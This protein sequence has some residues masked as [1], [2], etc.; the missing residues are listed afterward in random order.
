[1]RKG[2]VALLDAL[3]V[4]GIWARS[5]P[6]DVIT[7]WKHA[8]G[9]FE[10]SIQKAREASPE[11]KFSLLSFSDTVIILLETEK[12]PVA[13]IPL[14]AG[15]LLVPFNAALVEGIFLRGAVSV[16]EF[17][18]SE[19]MI[20]GPAVD[21]AAEWYTVPDWMGVSLCPS[22]SYGVERLAEQGA[23]ISRWFVKY[24]VPMKSGVDGG[25][26]WALAWPRF[27]LDIPLGDEKPLSARGVLLYTFARNGVSVSVHT[28][29]RNTLRFF[30]FVRSPVEEAHRSRSSRR[31]GRGG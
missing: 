6:R 27:A 17:V 15:V 21:E 14:M 28:K 9:M 1:M 30:D 18:R 26:G 24:D 8:I 12:D 5:R 23:D 13:C 2:V 19:S 20:I 16:G 11:E 4:K 3:G 31:L 25:A 22:A 7:A 29:Y 10:K